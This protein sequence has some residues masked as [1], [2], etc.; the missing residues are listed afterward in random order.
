M[1]NTAMYFLMTLL[2]L[3]THQ[4]YAQEELVSNDIT[5]NSFVQGTLLEPNTPTDKVVIL[6]AGSGPTDRNGNQQIAINNSLKF[7]AVAL[8]KKG[9]A[10]FRYD[11]R[12]I[13][14][15]KNGSL[16]EKKLRFDDFVTDA[17]SAISYFKENSSYKEV[18]VAGHSQGSLVGILAAQQTEIDGFISLAGAGQPIDQ[19][20]VNQIAQQIP[21]LKDE[22]IAAFKTLA[23]KGEV[24]EYNPALG[25]IFRK[26]VQPFIASWMR[27]NPGEALSTLEI[28]VLLVNGTK[29]LQ[30][31]LEEVNLLKEALPTAQL[32]II[33][34]MNH[35][36][37]TIEGDT[38]ENAKS[39]NE[40]SKPIN[41]ELVTVVV[42]F[43]VNK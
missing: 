19:T 28:P 1:N 15:I 41:T 36:L 39:Y 13:P 3:I 5:V 33:E 31:S 7:L 10:S 35:V 2:L 11:K 29:D 14:L 42:D 9:I 38:L 30:V 4:G 26:S 8:A 40:G 12:I 6:I 37:K 43:I 22:T 17:V 20:I 23:E 21:G 27:Y 25:S 24:T 16:D 34:N 18:Y 32:S